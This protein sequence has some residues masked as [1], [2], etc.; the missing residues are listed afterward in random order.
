MY[1]HVRENSIF[2]NKNYAMPYAFDSDIETVSPSLFVHKST[3]N[4]VFGIT[5]TIRG[6]ID[7]LNSFDNNFK[8]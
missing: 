4:I 7:G 1:P 3:F 5:E 6:I 2:L 8:T